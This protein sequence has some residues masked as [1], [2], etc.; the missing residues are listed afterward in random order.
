MA[1]FHPIPTRR[2]ITLTF[3]F[4]AA[5]CLAAGL[6]GWRSAVDVHEA[7]VQTQR[8][9]ELDS[10]VNA[11]LRSLNELILTSGSKASAEAFQQAQKSLEGHLGQAP[12]A[13]AEPVRRWVQGVAALGAMKK[14]S[15]DNDEVMVAYGKLES[16]SSALLQQ[17]ATLATEQR[18][19]TQARVDRLVGLAL[20]A[21][22]G[23]FAAVAAVGWLVAR[24]LHRRLGGELEEAEAVVARVAGGDFAPVPLAPGAEGMLGALARMVAQLSGSIGEVRQAAEQIRLAADEV[25]SGSAD[26]GSRTEQAAGS[27]QSSAGAIQQVVGSVR[28]TAD[29]ARDANEL[30]AQAAAVAQRGGAQVAEVVSTMERIR[31]SSQRIGDI[32]GT[33][34]GIAFQTNILALNAAV[35]AARAGEQGRGFAVVAAEVRAL[36]QRSAH[37]A[38]EIK[39]LVTAS[40]DSVESGVALVAS[41]GQTI[42]SIVEQAERVSG[43]V[44]GIS[45]AAREQSSGIEQVSGSVLELERATQQNAALVEQS[46]AAASLLRDQATRLAEVVQAFRTGAH[47]RA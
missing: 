17:L 45:A 35:E 41:T 20:A 38:R 3:G 19:A 10:E 36:A 9:L 2:L 24:R 21:G 32:I 39:A 27:L 42:Q 33:I 6:A 46:T 8:V 18:A 7:N 28:Q 31:G 43:V 34:D 13:L 26:L 30:A 22:L 15:P 44:G 12:A 29:H 40:V 4:A 16:Q 11:S 25:A 5:A 37:A 47:A 23:L 1:F 14:P